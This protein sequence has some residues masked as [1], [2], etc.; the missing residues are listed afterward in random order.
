MQSYSASRF[1]PKWAGNRKA[2]AMPSSTSGLAAHARQ[3]G[4][5]EMLPGLFGGLHQVGDAVGA[6]RLH[7]VR[8]DGLQEHGRDPSV[9]ESEFK[10]AVPSITARC[11]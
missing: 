1:L 5:Q 2:V 4:V 10:S 9:S 11:G 7:D 8:T 3:V 6:D